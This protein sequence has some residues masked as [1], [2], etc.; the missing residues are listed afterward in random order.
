MSSHL[1]VFLSSLVTRLHASATKRTSRMRMSAADIAYQAERLTFDLPCT[2]ICSTIYNWG[3]LSA[4]SSWDGG[5][6]A[7]GDA[8][9]IAARAKLVWC[10]FSCTND[11]DPVHSHKGNWD[12]D[13]NPMLL[14][15]YGESAMPCMW[16]DCEFRLESMDDPPKWTLVRS[17]TCSNSWMVCN[18][19]CQH[20]PLL[21]L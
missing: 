21:L 17:G 4:A 10:R 13:K 18:L 3:A 2:R 8:G 7:S 9:R 6:C 14:G 16:H 20:F 19:A 1:L 15:I 12:A 5:G 11:Y